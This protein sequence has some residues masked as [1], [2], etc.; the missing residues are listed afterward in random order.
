ME[1]VN[2]TGNIFIYYSPVGKFFIKYDFKVCKWILGL[3]EEVFGFYESTVAA[4]DDVYC[5]ASGCYEWDS[6]DI[7]SILEDVPT[8]IYCWEFLKKT[9]KL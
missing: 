5:Q 7:D 1:S 9:T 2:N 6:M 4:A 8:D 3:G